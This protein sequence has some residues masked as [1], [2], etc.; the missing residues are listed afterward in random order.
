MDFE[1]FHYVCKS[2]KTKCELIQL[3]THSFTYIVYRFRILVNGFYI[4][5]L[6]F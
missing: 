6:D 5:N 2:L 1:G 4:L 3:T